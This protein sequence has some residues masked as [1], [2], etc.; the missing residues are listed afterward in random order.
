MNKPVSPSAAVFCL[1]LREKELTFGFFVP[2]T[3]EENST[4][5]H[6]RVHFPRKRARSRLLVD[7]PIQIFCFV[8]TAL[9]LCKS[10]LP[11]GQPENTHR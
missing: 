2:S 11:G 4:L 7:N 10:R 1:P 8:D 3:L 6:A 5:S 9:D